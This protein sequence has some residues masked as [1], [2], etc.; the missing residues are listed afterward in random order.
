MTSSLYY[1]SQDHG[2]RSVLLTGDP[3]YSMLADILLTILH[4][5]LTRLDGLQRHT[6]PGPPFTGMG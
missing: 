1:E 5:H 3:D 6:A 2:E 4:Y